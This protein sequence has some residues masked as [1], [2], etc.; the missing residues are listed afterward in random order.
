M[1]MN[2]VE[3][4][5]SNVTLERY[6]NYAIK[7]TAHGEGYLGVVMEVNEVIQQ[8]VGTSLDHV[9]QSLRTWVDA[10]IAKKAKDR[11]KRKPTQTEYNAAA[12]LIYPTLNAVQQ[13]LLNAHICAEG[14]TA[15]VDSLLN[16]ANIHSTIQLL[17]EY[18]TIARRLSDAMAYSPSLND[19]LID[20]IV[21]VLLLPTGLV[22]RHHHT[23]EL[24]LKPEAATAFS[25]C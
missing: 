4:N 18:A 12:A 15:S 6:R 16:A 11:G 19:D 7:I 5:H 14:S 23:R 8:Q 21:Q 1:A 13:K 17:L 2:S 20:P 22:S 10:L 9:I 24:A 3:L 25:L